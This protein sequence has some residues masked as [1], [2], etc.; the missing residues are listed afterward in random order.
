M[1]R[2]KNV[3]FVGGPMA[4]ECLPI[5]ANAGE[6]VVEIEPDY[7]KIAQMK[8]LEAANAV[9][10]SRVRYSISPYPIRTPEGEPLYVGM[11]GEQHLANVE[12]TL[13][14]EYRYACLRI[15]N[16]EQQLKEKKQ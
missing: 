11:I 5:P 6:W 9:Q 10:Q 8:P 4:G 1:S 16:L 7:R 13:A 3:V 12:S 14:L 15:K 2:A